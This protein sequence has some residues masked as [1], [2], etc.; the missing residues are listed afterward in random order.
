MRPVSSATNTATQD[1][2]T[3]PY[4]LIDMGFDPA[5]KFSTCGDLTWEG[6][7]LNGPITVQLGNQPS[8]S[9]FNED[10]LFGQIVLAQGTSS[11]TIDIYQGYMNDA[12]HPNPVMVFSGEMGTAEIGE[13]VV[14]QCKQSRPSMTPRHYCVPPICNHMPAPGTRFS[15][16]RG[17]VI[18]ESR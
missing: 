8:V 17:I 15:T 7:W 9:V 11:R 18:L 3:R 16:T 12:N 10:L 5:I 13:Q 2:I 4:Y 6:S 1:S 14:I